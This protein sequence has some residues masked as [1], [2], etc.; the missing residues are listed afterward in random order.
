MR[1]R[2]E[3]GAEIK[4]TW[5]F[6]WVLGGRRLPGGAVDKGVRTIP[7]QP[8]FRFG[9]QPACRGEWLCS[10]AGTAQLCRDN[11]GHSRVLEGCCEGLRTLC[12][13]RSQRGIIGGLS[14]LLGMADKQ[15][16]RRQTSALGRLGSG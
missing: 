12:P 13:R 2:D 15:N 5:P 16:Q 7:K 11:G 4:E 6:A 14:G 1:R 10:L 9:G 8:T 3:G